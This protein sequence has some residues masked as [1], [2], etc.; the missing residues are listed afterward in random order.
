MPYRGFPE[1][2]LRDSAEFSQSKH[3][4]MTFIKDTKVIANECVVEAELFSW[5]CEYRKP[6]FQNNGVTVNSDH[7]HDVLR[8]LEE[9]NVLQSNNVLFKFTT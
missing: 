9:I 7:A 2:I 4:R 3:S 6:R 8:K 1:W 5:V